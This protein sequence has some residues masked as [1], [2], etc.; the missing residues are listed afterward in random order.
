MKNG[1]IIGLLLVLVVLILY[2]RVS[3]YDNSLIDYA[4]Q[5]MKEHK[6]A[7]EIL[8]ALEAKGASQK[9]AFEIAKEAEKRL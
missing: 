7:V 6:T 9:D 3:C 8:Q 1:I 2:R 4:T 5:L